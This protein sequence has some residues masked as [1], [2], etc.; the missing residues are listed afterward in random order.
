LDA[1]RVAVITVSDGVVAGEREDHSG[2]TIVEW[3]KQRGHDVVARETVT[4]D[5]DRIAACL[6][7]CCDRGDADLVLTTGGTGFTERDITPE[8]TRAVIERDAPGIPEAIRARGAATT[9]Y[10][11]LSRGIAG[12]RGGSLIVNLPGSE[13]GVRDGLAVLDVVAAHAAQLVRGIDTG[14]HPAPNG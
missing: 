12:L 1:I 2:N 14:R 5:A 13:S 4:D 7:L 3:A 11:C 6:I 8:A 10:A 9:P